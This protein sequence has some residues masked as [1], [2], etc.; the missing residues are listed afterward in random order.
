MVTA[1]HSENRSLHE[2]C[3]GALPTYRNAFSRL[4][5]DEGFFERHRLPRATLLDPLIWRRDTRAPEI[6]DAEFAPVRNVG[7]QNKYFHYQRTVNH[8]RAVGTLE[9]FS[10]A[11]RLRN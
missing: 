10:S 5:F 3:A 4:E 8:R 11:V 7:A 6:A 1:D 9:W 2:K